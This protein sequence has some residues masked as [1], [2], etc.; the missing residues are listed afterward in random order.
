MLSDRDASSSTSAYRARSEG[1]PFSLRSEKVCPNVR[2]AL[3]SASSWGLPNGASFSLWQMLH[4]AFEG[5]VRA[6]V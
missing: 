1:V 6:A 3:A 5:S 2:G 4:S